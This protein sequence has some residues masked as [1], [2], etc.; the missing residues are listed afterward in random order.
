VITDRPPQSPKARREFERSD[1]LTRLVPL[2]DAHDLQAR[3]TLLEKALT[4]G[5][6]RSVK[7]EGESMLDLL[8]GTYA[9]S[10]ARL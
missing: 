7:T 2:P 10:R 8:A 6:A 9:I 4:L 3:A 1:A 5:D